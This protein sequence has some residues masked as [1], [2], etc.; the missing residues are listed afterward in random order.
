VALSVPAAEVGTLEAEL[1]KVEQEKA[2]PIRL[3]ATTDG[4]IR[5]ALPPAWVDGERARGCARLDRL[6][7]AGDC[8]NMAKSGRPRKDAPREVI[9]RLG[10]LNQQAQR[11]DEVEAETAALERAAAAATKAIDAV[12]EVI[13]LRVRRPD[14]PQRPIR[15]RTP[16]IDT[17]LEWGRGDLTREH[18]QA[19]QDSFALLESAP[20]MPV[21]GAGLMLRQAREWLVIEAGLG[22][23]EQRPRPHVGKAN[24]KEIPLRTL[25]RYA[26]VGDV[27]FARLQRSGR[28]DDLS[29]ES[30]RSKAKRQS[31]G[32]KEA[33]APYLA[34]LEE[35]LLALI[36]QQEKAFPNVTPEVFEAFVAKV[37]E[38]ERGGRPL[39]AV[40]PGIPW[41][42]VR[43]GVSTMTPQDRE[44]IAE[45]LWESD[46]L[47]SQVT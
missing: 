29:F 22:P 25:L 28:P 46:R 5:G 14:R 2:R 47:L 20:V 21:Y 15:T 33:L 17:L 27:A 4:R 18:G 12:E 7:R 11:I 26:G 6:R 30:R 37:E 32:R 39:K 44:A 23:F 38:A 3:A 34:N 8:S 13:R 45:L 31:A 10:K 43:A 41:D 16:F 35:R 24:E 36:G 42:L 19:A 40:A 1:K 9:R